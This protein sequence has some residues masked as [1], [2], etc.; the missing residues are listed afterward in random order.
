MSGKYIAFFVF[1]VIFPYHISVT[2]G[3]VKI[4]VK[5]NGE[6]LSLV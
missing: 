5:N 6:P 3:F 4:V 1:A 2:Y